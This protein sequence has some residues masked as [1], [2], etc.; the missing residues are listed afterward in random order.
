MQ[1][2][3]MQEMDKYREEMSAKM[4]SMR[5]ANRTKI[6]SILTEEQKKFLES[7]PAVP[8]RP[9]MPANPPAIKQ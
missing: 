6:M 3:Q 2:K 8:Q 5:E 9:G 1:Q 7:G 4:Q